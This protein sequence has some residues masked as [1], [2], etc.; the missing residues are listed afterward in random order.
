[1]AGPA[2]AT[3][4]SFAL[5]LDMSDHAPVRFKALP[6]GYSDA[7]SSHPFAVEPFGIKQ[8][9]PAPAKLPMQAPSRHPP[10]IKL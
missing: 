3:S 6:E 1:M 4:A 8:D 5:F 10:A 9:I 7:R 2:A